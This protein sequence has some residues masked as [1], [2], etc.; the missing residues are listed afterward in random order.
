M[1]SLAQ[2]SCSLDSDTPCSFL[3][4][5]TGIALAFGK[6]SSACDSL[7]TFSLLLRV[8]F[9]TRFLQV[10][11]ADAHRL[12]KRTGSESSSMWQRG[13][14]RAARVSGRVTGSFKHTQSH[15]SRSLRYTSSSSSSSS[16]RHLDNDALL[17]AGIAA[18][19]VGT[20]LYTCNSASVVLAEGPRPDARMRRRVRRE[21]TDRSITTSTW[22]YYEGSTTLKNFVLLTGNSN[23]SLCNQIARYLGIQRAPAKVATYADGETAVEIKT[24]TS[25]KHVVIVQ[26]MSAP[27]NDNIIELLLM[28]SAVRRDNAKHVTLVLPYFGYG[29]Q[30][31]P[32][33]RNNESY[34]D[35]D[36]FSPI[37]AADVALM[38]SQ[39]GVDR[40]LT[41]DL[42]SPQASWPAPARLHRAV[43]SLTPVFRVF[44]R[45][46]AFS[47]P[48]L[49][50]IVFSVQASVLTISWRNTSLV[51]ALL[52]ELVSYPGHTCRVAAR[53]LGVLLTRVVAGE[54]RRRHR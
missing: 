27:T 47:L 42:H 32:R 2:E 54:R 52:S 4:Q 6:K 20:V 9:G 19:A 30:D 8:C 16:V 22:H 53:L 10:A 21:N 3:A 44:S 46:P 43:L 35:Y 50:T 49:R 28:V 14:A 11:T 26:S 37:S 7:L 5:S 13:L 18:A 51:I 15:T 33:Q 34:E 31:T 29:R 45:S 40:V 23:P 12:V 36:T 41:L 48:L 39:S 1:L 38:I 17:K 24:N 25:G